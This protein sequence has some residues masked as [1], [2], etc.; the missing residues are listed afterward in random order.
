MLG[1]IAESTASHSPQGVDGIPGDGAAP[2]VQLVTKMYAKGVSLTRAA[3]ARVEAQVQR[4]PGLEAWFVDIL[5][6]PKA[7]QIGGGH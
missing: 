6:A 4:L 3:M 2:I 7:V 5:C 1:S